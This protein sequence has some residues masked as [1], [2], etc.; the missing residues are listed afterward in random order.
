MEDLTELAVPP[1]PAIP[2]GASALRAMFARDYGHL[3]TF[4]SRPTFDWMI[5]ELTSDRLRL[6]SA[7]LLGMTSDSSA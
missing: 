6:D 2:A 4:M 1:A 7:S 5:D 3:A